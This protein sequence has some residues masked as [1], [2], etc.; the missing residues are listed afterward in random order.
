MKYL[1]ENQ[2]VVQSLLAVTKRKLLASGMN[3]RIIRK[4]IKGSQEPDKTICH[5]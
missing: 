5:E 3:E 2:C 4:A 1:K